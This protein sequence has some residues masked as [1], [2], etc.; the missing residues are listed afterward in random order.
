MLPTA[1]MLLLIAQG[2][3]FAQRAVA[4]DTGAAI[5]FRR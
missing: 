1:L 5:P 2:S 3:V 4:V